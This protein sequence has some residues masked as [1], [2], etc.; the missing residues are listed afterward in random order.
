MTQHQP[1]TATSAIRSALVL[2][3][4]ALAAA[5]SPAAERTGKLV[6]RVVDAESG[7]GISDAGVQVVGTTMGTSS[8]VDGRYTIANVP[9][10]TITI[11]VRR[12][13]YQ[14][15]TVTGLLLDAGQ[16]LEQSVS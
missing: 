13:G 15:K 3:F 2:A 12:I 9:A 5:R 1:R 10:G 16:T 14:P 11:Q 8:G 7:A 4:I 6:G